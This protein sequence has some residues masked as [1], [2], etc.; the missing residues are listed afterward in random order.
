MPTI[1]QRQ[2]LHLLAELAETLAT[3]L[4]RHLHPTDIPVMAGDAFDMLIKVRFYLVRANMPVP[5]VIESVLSS[6]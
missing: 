4:R 3:E 6:K 5:P 1:D 2:T